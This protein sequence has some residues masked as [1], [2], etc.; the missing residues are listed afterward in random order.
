MFQV[1]FHW[2]NANKNFSEAM[3]RD[4]KYGVQNEKMNIIKSATTL[5]ILNSN[6]CFKVIEIDI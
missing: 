2:V 4:S 5:Q 6:A 1:S 3:S